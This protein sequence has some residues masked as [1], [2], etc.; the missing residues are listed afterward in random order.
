MRRPTGRQLTTWLVTTA[1]VTPLGPLAGLLWGNTIPR[2]GY[3][4]IQ[5][6]ALVAD[7][8]G[9][10][11][12]GVDGR[13]ALIAL[14]A[15][16]LCGIAAYLAGGRRNDIALLLGLAAGGV[17]ASLLAWKTGHLIGLGHYQD[18]VRHGRD[19]A[20]V[21][22]VPDL[23]AKGVLM[24][25]PLVAVAAYGLLE[26]VFRRLPPGD[27]RDGGAGEGDEVGGDELDLESAP[28][29]RDVDGGER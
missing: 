2:V 29:G 26:V 24:A 9:E 5:G 1:I 4:V 19:G 7:P 22:G 27:R 14:S 17:A 25:W 12:I 23:R 20:T 18:V 13:F 3:V 16:L 10:G 8:E 15:G 6:E 11:P 21:T 28:T